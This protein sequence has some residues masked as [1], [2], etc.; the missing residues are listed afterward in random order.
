MTIIVINMKVNKFQLLPQMDPRD[1]LH[2]ARWLLS[3]L[4]AV[5]GQIKLTILAKMGVPCEKKI[6]AGPAAWNSLPDNLQDPSRF[7]QLCH[8]TSVHSTLD[9]LR[10]S[11]V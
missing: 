2:H 1:A 5:V 10:L 9:A 3:L 4:S 6:M 11:A 7:W 8:A